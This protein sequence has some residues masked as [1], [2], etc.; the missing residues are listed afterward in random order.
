MPKR[1]ILGNLII[2]EATPVD[3]GAVENVF[4]RARRI[5]LT[6]AGVLNAEYTYSTIK[7]SPYDYNIQVFVAELFGKILGFTA[8]SEY[9]I[10]RIYVDPDHFGHGIGRALLEHALFSIKGPINI[11]ILSQNQR[12]LDLCFRHGFEVLRPT[13]IIIP[14]VQAIGWGYILHRT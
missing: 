5:E 11:E 14:E 3:S 10:E 4:E 12:A 13:S 2:R 8:T 1:P 6:C 9:E 7:S